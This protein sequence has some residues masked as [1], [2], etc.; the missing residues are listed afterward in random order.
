M[1]SKCI[2][3]TSGRKYV[4]GNELKWHRFL[5]GLWRGNFYFGAF[6]LLM[7]SLDH[8][9]TSSIKS[10]VIF[11]FGAPVFLLR[12]CSFMGQV[13]WNK[14]D[15]DKDGHFRRAAQF[16]ATFVTMMHHWCIQVILLLLGIHDVGTEKIYTGWHS[17]YFWTAHL[18][19]AYFSPQSAPKPFSGRALHSTRSCIAGFR[20]WAPGKGKQEKERK[21]GRERGSG[22][23]HPQFLKRG[24]VSV[25]E[26]TIPHFQLLKP[27]QRKY[28]KM[29]HMPYLLRSY[30][31]TT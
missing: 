15:Y 7:R 31:I 20:V 21:D 28:L 10:D 29:E 3:S 9:T 12:M 4:I 5:I 22:D 2:N 19:S 24:C 27:F 18:F 11:E 30:L 16:S 25:N 17:S 6:S 26:W 1:R 13:A 14:H 23:G 8:I